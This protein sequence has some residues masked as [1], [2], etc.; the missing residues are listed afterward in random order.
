MNLHPS[1]QETGILTLVSHTSP[2]AG[3]STCEDDGSYELSSTQFHTVE[4]GMVLSA[5]PPVNQCNQQAH[6]QECCLPHGE[7]KMPGGVVKAGI[8]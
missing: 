4:R 8:H 6:C 7:T 1:S 5:L 2:P 3:T